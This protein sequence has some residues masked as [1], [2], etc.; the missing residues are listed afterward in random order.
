MS[1]DDHAVQ[2]EQ[3]M[4]ATR[5]TKKWVQHSWLHHQ[6][7][8]WHISINAWWQWWQCIVRILVGPS[9]EL[10]CQLTLKWSTQAM[11]V[12]RKTKALITPPPRWNSVPKYYVWV[13]ARQQ[14]RW[15]SQSYCRPLI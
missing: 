7:E 6:G 14:S 4:A 2:V 11:A 13:S 1:H 12:D 8:F 10:Y 3:A 9:W 15:Y 5:K